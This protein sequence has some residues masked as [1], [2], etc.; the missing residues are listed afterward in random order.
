LRWLKIYWEWLLAAAAGVNIKLLCKIAASKRWTATDNC[1]QK[2]Q[3]H[4]CAAQADKKSVAEESTAHAASIA[5]G[6]NKQD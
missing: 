6:L 2:N 1:S 5:T 4:N 3:Y